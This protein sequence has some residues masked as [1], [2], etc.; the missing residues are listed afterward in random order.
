MVFYFSSLPASSYPNHPGDGWGVWLGSLVIDF[1]RGATWMASKRGGIRLVHGLTKSTLITY[2]SGMKID[3]KYA[4]LP[5]VFACIFLN[6]P[7]VSF[8]KFV[9]MTKNT[10]FFPIL[11]V[12][13]PLNDVRAYIAWS[14]KTTLIT[15][16]FGRAWYPLD[17]R[18]APRGDFLNFSF[19]FLNNISLT[20]PPC[21]DIHRARW[22]LTKFA[23]L[24][25]IVLIYVTLPCW[26]HSTAMDPAMENM[27][28]TLAQV[29]PFVKSSVATSVK[30]SSTTVSDDKFTF[31]WR[32]TSL[33]RVGYSCSSSEPK[34]CSS[35]ETSLILP[36]RD[37]WS[38]LIRPDLLSL[39]W[40]YS[41]HSIMDC[42]TISP[43]GVTPG[44]L[45][46]A[47]KQKRIYNS[48]SGR[49][50]SMHIS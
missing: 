26:K 9:Y 8:Q 27:A 6:L 5:G 41:L 49:I 23:K 12:F 14:W 39:F 42:S 48:Y 33:N 7:V 44:S 21:C 13:A 29:I 32:Q 16:I 43:S 36:E 31:S 4:F 34:Y 17:I 37:L 22:F 24:F 18:V 19:C 46:P 28:T 11:H 45:S 2:F 15:W 1:S 38:A 20:H 10:R 3:P 50:K 35:R 25:T 30:I 40:T 47:E